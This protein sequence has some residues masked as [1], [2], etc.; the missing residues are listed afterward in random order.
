MT[1][2]CQAACCIFF[3]AQW[4]RIKS[5][6]HHS[7]CVDSNSMSVLRINEIAKMLHNTL[8]KFG[9]AHEGVFLLQVSAFAKKKVNLAKTK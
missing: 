9:S 7:F 8:M 4:A 6:N 2:K 3:F 1:C 5:A